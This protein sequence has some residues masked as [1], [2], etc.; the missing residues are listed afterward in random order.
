MLVSGLIGAF[1]GGRLLKLLRHVSCF[2]L[3]DAERV[4]IYSLA[5]IVVVS[6]ICKKV[7]FQ[8][9]VQFKTFRD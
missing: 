2:L 7:Q 1:S 9:L 4:N 3:I 6:I 8:F 5:S